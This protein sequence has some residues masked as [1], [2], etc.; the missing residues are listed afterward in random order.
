M[1]N[2]KSKAV[3]NVTRRYTQ[4]ARAEAAEATAQR[5][6]DAFLRR[7][8]QDWF[9]EITLAQVA[10]EAGV[11]VQT[12]LRRFEGKEG[13]LATAIGTFAKQVNTRRACD[14]GDIDAAIA[15]LLKDYEQVGDAVL[16]LLALEARHPALQE[17]L[18]YGRGQH[19]S[20]VAEVF[21]PQ[22]SGLDTAA[23]TRALDGLVVATDVYTWKLIRRDMA[24]STA[25]TGAMIADLTR[26]VFREFTAR[27]RKGD[28][29]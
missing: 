9:D 6:V 17:A 24:R 3:Q 19:R 7:L 11:T 2:M 21:A 10:A 8:M 14:A 12:V 20:W 1:T 5:I 15:A 29:A 4:G 26:A 28:P 22:L 13:L 27:N 25:A 23:R 18:N 16:R